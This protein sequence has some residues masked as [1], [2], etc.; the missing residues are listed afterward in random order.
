MGRSLPVMAT[1]CDGQIRCKCLVKSNANGWASLC[2]YP[3]W[4]TFAATERLEPRFASSVA[5]GDKAAF[6]SSLRINRALV[7]V[8]IATLSYKID[9]FVISPTAHLSNPL[10][11]FR[12]SQLFDQ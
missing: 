6:A 8:Q 11:Q 9:G 10:Q 2:N 1:Q 3:F 12:V 4:L 7:L 5:A